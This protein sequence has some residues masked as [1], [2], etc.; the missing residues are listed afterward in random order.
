MLKVIGD[1]RH[2]AIDIRLVDG[3]KDPDFPSKLDLAVENVYRIWRETK[4]QKFYRVKDGAYDLS[5]PAD[6]GPATQM[7]FAN[8]GLTGKRGLAVPDYIRAELVR[9]GVPS[10]EIAFIADYKSHVA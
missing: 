3:E 1:G 6:I 7:L 10:S 9:R 5:K 8:L 4:R 2:A